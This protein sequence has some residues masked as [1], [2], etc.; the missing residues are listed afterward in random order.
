MKTNVIKSHINKE[1]TMLETVRTLHDDEI[2]AWYNQ[3][4]CAWTYKLMES[5]ETSDDDSSMVEMLKRFYIGDEIV[6]FGKL[7]FGEET[8]YYVYFRYNDYSVSGDFESI[9]EEI[10]DFVKHTVL[11]LSI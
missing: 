3:Y 5:V 2:T 7:H 11:K 6:E 1:I 4:A 10:M 9:M 8:E